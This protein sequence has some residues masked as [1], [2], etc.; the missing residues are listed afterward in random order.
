MQQP[1][2][3]DQRAPFCWNICGHTEH[4]FKTAQPKGDLQVFSRIPLIFLRPPL[5]TQGAEPIR[6]FFGPF[7]I[8]LDGIKFFMDQNTEKYYS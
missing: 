6:D 4:L 3:S 5:N 7:R 2:G 1:T 8:M